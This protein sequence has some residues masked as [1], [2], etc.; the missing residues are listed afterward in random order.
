[1]LPVEPPKRFRKPGKPLCVVSY[2][3]WIMGIMAVISAI[4]LPQYTLW[5]SLPLFLSVLI[6]G[7]LLNVFQK[8]DDDE[9]ENTPKFDTV[10]FWIQIGVV[11]L[12]VLGFASMM[13]I[14][15]GPD[16]VDGEYCIVSHG[17]VVRYITPAFY[18]LIQTAESGSMAGLLYMFSSQMLLTCRERRRR[19]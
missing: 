8:Q 17:D 16:I 2:A 19:G 4:V 1:M 7:I 15:G 11:I 18:R 10:L 14:G 9:E 6:Q 3:T 13:L 12:A 5:F